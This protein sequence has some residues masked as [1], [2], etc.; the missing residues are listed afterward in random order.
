MFGNW[1]PSRYCYWFQQKDAWNDSAVFNSYLK[2]IDFELDKKI[3]LLMDNVSFHHCINVK[4][5]NIEPVYL[6][7]N[8]T[9][10]LQPLDLGIIRSFKCYYKHSLS[11]HN[12]SSYKLTKTI[13]KLNAKQAII[14]IKRA[15]NRVK[16]STVANCFKKSSL[17][18]LGCQIETNEQE[19]NDRMEQDMIK[20]E[21]EENMK[22]LHP[23]QTI[24]VEFMLNIENLSEESYKTRSM[25]DVNSITEGEVNYIEDT[26]VFEQSPIHLFETLSEQKQNEK[27]KTAIK[28]LDS[29]FELLSNIS[30][31]TASQLTKYQDI[32]ATLRRISLKFEKRVK[33]QSIKK[34]LIRKHK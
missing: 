7:P 25:G 28:S 21:I 5:N 26:D 18:T 10:L 34:W 22:E 1:D 16:P 27:I 24:D 33:C 13:P 19:I 30:E 14:K 29:Q 23:N 4:L 8:S 11:E 31:L 9:F 12:L 3:A 6:P 2:K 20:V 17:L 15:W 32:I